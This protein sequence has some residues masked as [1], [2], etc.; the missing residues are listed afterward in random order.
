M[1]VRQDRSLRGKDLILGEASPAQLHERGH[2]QLLVPETV[3]LAGRVEASHGDE[4]EGPLV[5]GSPA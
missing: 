1:Y 4:L 5:H 3:D 2:R